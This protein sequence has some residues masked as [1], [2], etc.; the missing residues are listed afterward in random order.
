M[1]KNLQ[2]GDS[3]KRRSGE[4]WEEREK[5]CLNEKERGEKVINLKGKCRYLYPI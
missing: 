3:S 4:L 1:E 5:V 2:R